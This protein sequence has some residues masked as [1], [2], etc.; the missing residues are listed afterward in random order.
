VLGPSGSC[1]L[2]G[3]CGGD[4]GA[5]RQCGAM[6]PLNAAFYG[7]GGGGACFGR[8]GFGGLGGGG[9][10]AF[11]N[12]GQEAGSAGAPGSGGGGG[13]SW[14]SGSLGPTPGSAGGSGAVVVAWAVAR[15]EQYED[16]LAGSV[17]E[18]RVYARALAARE[19]LALSQ[20]PL[21]FAGAVNPAPVA[22]A[23]SYA[24]SQCAAGFAGA[25]TLVWTRNTETNE[26]ARA[27]A[28]A[29]DACTPGSFAAA[30]GAAAC[31]RCPPGVWTAG[32]RAG[33]SS[34]AKL[35]APL[36]P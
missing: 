9:A 29:C 16:R 25:A 1:G 23:L 36:M 8:H 26:W 20:P 10:A 13:A 34:E 28:L 11:S 30:A 15:P 22:G 14:S 27:G 24:W 35:V 21:A 17:A 18:L 32:S 12:E 4:G 6:A 2:G 7:G 19:V 33:S 3:I 31:D 5:G